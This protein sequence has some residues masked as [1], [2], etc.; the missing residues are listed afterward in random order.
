M[1]N[2][3]H[4]PMRSSYRPGHSSETALV[5]ATNDLLSAVDRRQAI[6][7]VL[8]NLS[9]AFN[10]VDHEVLLNRLKFDCSVREIPLQWIRSYLT[11]RSQETTINDISLSNITLQYGVSQGVCTG[12]S[13]IYMLRQTSREQR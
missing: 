4:Q 7:L 8:L 1:A 13:S 11:G 6:I 5:R 10:T 12:S 2:G 3:L 9:A